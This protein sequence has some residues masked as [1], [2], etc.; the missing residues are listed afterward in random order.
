MSSAQTH[1]FTR[2]RRV[3]CLPPTMS[4]NCKRQLDDFSSSNFKR[5]RYEAIDAPVSKDNSFLPRKIMTI[6]QMQRDERF[7][8]GSFHLLAGLKMSDVRLTPLSIYQAHVSSRCDSTQHQ[9]NNYTALKDAT[10]LYT[11]YMLAGVVKSITP[12]RKT[13]NGTLTILCRIP[14]SSVTVFDAY[15]LGLL[16]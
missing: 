10:A 9:G 14:D 15:R 2:S 7:G 6:K 13:K 11:P 1:I 8:P 3:F 16:C 5:A 4:T 12:A